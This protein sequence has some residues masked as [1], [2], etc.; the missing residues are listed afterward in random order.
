MFDSN[1]VQT[2][3]F[4]KP[5]EVKDLGSFW[6]RSPPLTPPPHTHNKKKGNRDLSHSFG[7]PLRNVF[8][9]GPH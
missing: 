5:E 3:S 2:S 1:L 7:V 4:T 8:V 6:N 9:F